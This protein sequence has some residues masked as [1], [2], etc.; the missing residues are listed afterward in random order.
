MDKA[1]E[2]EI[3]YWVETSKHD[4]KTMMGL[5][6]IKRYS[7]SLFYGH[8]VLEKILKAL[9]VQKTAEKPP[10]IHN[11]ETLAVLAELE[12]DKKDIDLLNIVSR[13]NIRAR[14]PNFK[15]D[16]YKMCTHKFTIEY[17]DKIKVLYSKL[18]RKVKLKK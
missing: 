13:F 5:F 3:K 1:T 6:R 14:Y 11:L 4:H 16:F 7:D 15:L 10:K 12:L 8:V 2:N 18:C 17:L 9:V